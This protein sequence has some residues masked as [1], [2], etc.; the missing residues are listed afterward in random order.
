MARTSSPRYSGPTE[1]RISSAALEQRWS[2]LT[3]GLR[4]RCQL[5]RGDLLVR[6]DAVGD[7]VT[8]G[9]VGHACEYVTRNRGRPTFAVP[10]TKLGRDDL[11]SWLGFNEKWELTSRN[12]YCFHHVSLT[13]YFGYEG[14]SIKPQIFRSEW[15]GI[16]RWTDEKIGFQS[17]GAGHP[18]WQFDAVQSTLDVVTEVRTKSLAR[19][20]GE[21]VT[22]DFSPQ[23]PGAD[24][25]WAA[26]CVS[27][28]NMHFASAA[29]WW[30]NPTHILTPHMNA[31][32]DADAIL[33]WILACVS[34][35]RQELERC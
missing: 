14:N 28:E 26:R 32:S 13:V 30:Q 35:M 34:Y 17:P 4:T 24:T 23:S 29:P 3:E 19:L 21:E 8:A 33:R 5:S 6:A 10:F 22:V 18:H 15:P 20:Q 11:K 25:I 1:V 9:L 31:P 12:S 16:R 7:E 27:L 2:S